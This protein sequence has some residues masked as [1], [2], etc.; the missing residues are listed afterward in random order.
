[1][2][3]SSMFRVVGAIFSIDID[4]DADDGEQHEDK[5]D[6]GG[7]KPVEHAGEA[8]GERGVGGAAISG[9]CLCGGD[10]RYKECDECGDVSLCCDAACEE[11][12]HV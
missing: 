11:M 9:G 4:G 7:V 10:G 2:G 12:R 3:R 8:A 5:E 6:S 1:M